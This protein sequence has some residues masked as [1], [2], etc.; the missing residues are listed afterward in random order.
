MCK[1]GDGS[2]N[3]A[4]G[5]VS[6]VCVEVLNQFPEWVDHTPLWVFINAADASQT[7]PAGVCSGTISTRQD[8][9]ICLAGWKSFGP[10]PSADSLFTNGLKTST[11]FAAVPV[12]EK[13]PG[14][15]SG[16]YYV[17][18]FR[19]VYLSTFY[20][21]CNA[22]TCDVVHSPGESSPLPCP[23]PLTSTD[24]SCGWFANGNKTVVAL[25]SFILA[26]DM[27]HPDIRDNFPA[28]EG[29]VIFN[30]SK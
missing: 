21:K 23:N 19:P 30:L 7:V 6:P 8:M 1:D 3:P 18:A 10:H 14:N 2:E 9:E 11:R 25:T 13:D 20:L 16:T 5:K 28:I 26:L 22:K 24:N 15:G 29:T 4:E 12:L 27:L 17:I